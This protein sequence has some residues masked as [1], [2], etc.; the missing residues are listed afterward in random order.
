MAD[1]EFTIPGYV[2]QRRLGDGGMATVFLAVQQSLDRSVAIKIMRARGGEDNEEKRF[3]LEA[4]TLARLP[5][6]N[7]VAV[8]DIAQ[9]S[10]FNYIVMEYLRGGV[11]SERM[12]AGLTMQDAISIVAQIADA[13][14]FAHENG[15]IHR[16]LKPA[17]VLFRN[18]STPVLTDF[19][20]AR[21]QD[22]DATRLTRPGMVIGTPAYMSPE[23]ALG[24]PVDG[25]SDQYSLG[26]L[27]Y[28]ML[29]RKLPFSGDNTMALA[30]HH[31]NTAPPPLPLRFDFAQPLI[32]KMMAKNPKERYPDLK[33][34]AR[35]LRSVVTAGQSQNLQQML[36]SA[37][38]QTDSEK[39]RA[40]GFSDNQIHVSGG[41]SSGPALRVSPAILPTAEDA[42]DLSPEVV[43]Y[44]ILEH[45][46]LTLEAVG[47]SDVL[48]PVGEVAPMKAAKGE[49]F[50]YS[51]PQAVPRLVD[52][53]KATLG[54]PKTDPR[55]AERVKTALTGLVLLVILIL[56]MKYYL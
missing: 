3:M 2:I 47:G 22:T 26:V 6:P 34:F 50:A 15:V 1:P 19:G 13:L 24:A 42:K 44:R 55:R 38:G 17:N 29:A 21:L 31:V 49:A 12:K 4:R 39:L 54:K 10:D 48:R 27:F 5:H 36:K 43:A 30:Y 16:D 33:T 52:P 8:H 18:A 45:S 25:R 14:Q 56:A 9:A 41:S 46:S 11:L 53:D 35:E 28:E 7:I 37:P 20:I 40:L 51:K 32:E 23:Q